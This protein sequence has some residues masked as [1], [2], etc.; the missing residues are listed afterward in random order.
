MSIQEQHIPLGGGLDE[1]SAGMIVP[2][3]C[4]WRGFNVE[5]KRLG[6]YRRM[7]GYVKF[8]QDEVPGEG[9]ILGVWRYND[10]VYAFRNAVGGATAAMYES[11]GTGWTLK[12]S[13]LAPDG[14]YEFQNYTF[15]G[16]QKMYGVSK[17]HKAFEWD[18][19]TWTDITTGMADDTPDH[20][21]AHR[22]RLFL[23]FG[24]SL[25]Y[26]P[27]NDPGGTWSTGGAGEILMKG[28]ITKVTP[29]TGGQLGIFSRN[30]VAILS[31]STAS[32][33]V[34]EQLAEHGTEIGCIENTLQLMGT[35]CYF[36][37]DR[38]VVDLFT[39]Q[40][41][42]DFDDS[43]VSQMIADTIRYRKTDVT[44]SCV[45]RDKTQY[46]LFFNDGRGLV[47]TFNGPQ[48]VGWM[49]IEWPVIVRCV[50]NAETSTGSEV[51]YF[52]SD[53]DGYVRQMEQT[54][55]FDGAPIEAYMYLAL[56]NLGA[57]RITKRIRRCV[58][59]MKVSGDT[60]LKIKPD[61][62]FERDIPQGYISPWIDGVNSVPLGQFVLGTDVLGDAEISQGYIDIPGMCEYISLHFYSNENKPQWEIDGLIYEFL[63]GRRMRHG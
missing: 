43:T 17:T 40:K 24:Q 49:P 31:G 57:P 9:G 63:V 3:G 59:D 5:Q 44:A 55:T 14:Q 50:C 12:K 52:G 34:V 28:P 25:Q 48:V 46:R 45:V 41:F 10:K 15:T 30:N 8:D 13:G 11:V 21:C 20:L 37:D 23:S 19:T 7:M 60:G 16:T 32:D 26:S 36:L 58:L 35:R 47:A 51:I 53:A 61:F 38:G 29:L 2:P 18:G 33:F 4:V 54:H 42:G 39:T 27:V 1:R 62:W 56:T 6:G 22:G